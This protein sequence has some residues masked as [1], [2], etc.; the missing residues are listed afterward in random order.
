MVFTFSDQR[1]AKRF[2]KVLPKRLYKFGLEMHEDKSQL[3]AA[4]HLHAAKAERNL[5]RLPTFKFLGFTCYWGKSK[6]GYWCLKY[7]SRRDRFTGKLKGMKLF[8]NKNL[9]TRDALALLKLVVVGIKGWINYHAISDNERRVS[10]FLHAS[11]RIIFRWFNRRGGNKRIS[12][13][14]FG[15]VLKAIEFPTRWKTISMYQSR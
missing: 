14:T 7:T 4:G 10:Q 12:W 2:Y 15:R 13:E 9:N 3:I 1:D 5:K 11:R 8:L 6:N